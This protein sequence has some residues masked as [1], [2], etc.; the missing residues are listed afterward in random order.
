[1]SRVLATVLYTAYLSTN[2][3]SII[4]KIRKP[5]CYNP[6]WYSLKD[7]KDANHMSI[8]YSTYMCFPLLEFSQTL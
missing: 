2:Q 1:M 7:F 6:V 5:C 4:L 3:K 8:I